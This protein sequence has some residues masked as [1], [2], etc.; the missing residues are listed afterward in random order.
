[1]AAVRRNEDVA[2]DEDSE[3]RQEM[4]RQQEF[5]AFSILYMRDPRT[6]CEQYPNLDPAKTRHQKRIPTSEDDV[7]VHYLM[8]AENRLTQQRK[9]QEAHEQ[10]QHAMLMQ[11][12]QKPPAINND[13]LAEK[14][15]RTPHPYEVERRQ[16]T[17]TLIDQYQKRQR[18]SNEANTKLKQQAMA[19]GLTLQPT[20]ME[21]NPNHPYFK[22]VVKQ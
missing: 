3:T 9:V 21:R 14:I 1:M 6:A 16:Q 8:A 15:K 5:K 22:Y 17:Q 2:A 20:P 4:Q 19:V 18:E 11:S 10:R 7:R 13:A 12:I